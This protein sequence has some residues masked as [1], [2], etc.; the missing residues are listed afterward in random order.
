MTNSVDTNDAVKKFKKYLNSDEMWHGT[1]KFPENES[2][3]AAY[4]KCISHESAQKYCPVRWKSVMTWARVSFCAIVYLSFTYFRD[5][6]FDW[7]YLY[8]CIF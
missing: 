1:L 4:K 6:R 7:E 3:E 8:C 5:G 2:N